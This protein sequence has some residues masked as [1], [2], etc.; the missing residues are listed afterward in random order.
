ME[1]GIAAFMASWVP[2]ALVLFEVPRVYISIRRGAH[3]FPAER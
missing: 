1:K 3:D 2:D